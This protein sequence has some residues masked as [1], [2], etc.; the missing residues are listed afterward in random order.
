MADWIAFAINLDEDAPMADATPDKGLDGRWLPLLNAQLTDNE[1]YTNDDL[2]NIVNEYKGRATGSEA[3]VRLGLPTADNSE[4]VGKIG[5]LKRVGSILIGQFSGID[6]RAEHLYSRGAFPKKS[7]EIN[8]SPDGDSLKSVGLIHPTQR[9][10]SGIPG[11]SPS[12]DMLMKSLSGDRTHV[13]GEDRKMHSAEVISHLKRCGRWSARYDRAGLPAMLA[14]LEGTSAFGP[15]AKFIEGLA[16]TCDPNGALLTECAKYY[17]REHQIT[18]G[19]ALAEIATPSSYTTTPATGPNP[20]SHGGAWS[21]P[22]SPAVREQERQE[23][24]FAIDQNILPEEIV[25][26]AWSLAE[27]KG[28][29]F[30]WAL[31]QVQS[32]NPQIMQR[33]QSERRR[34]RGGV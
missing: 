18:F 23:G 9:G 10:L 11:K 27:S 29:P 26:L 16:D 4:T 25:K 13:F 19:E 3:P 8:R 30:N 2:D 17:A 6:P 22:I 31:K 15:T 28:A 14:R 34:A 33:F 1:N 24:Q 20:D 5:A 7:V 21:Q 12:L 32:E